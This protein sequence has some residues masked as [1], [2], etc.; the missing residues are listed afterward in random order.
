MGRSRMM[1]TRLQLV[2]VA[3]RL[4]TII[5]S[6]NDTSGLPVLVDRRWNATIA[7]HVSVQ[8]AAARSHIFCRQVRGVRTLTVNANTI[9]HGLSGSMSPATAAFCLVSDLFQT[10]AFGN[11]C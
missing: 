10:G 11:P 6:V 3:A 9:S 8:D 2:R 7:A 4:V 1:S 5:A